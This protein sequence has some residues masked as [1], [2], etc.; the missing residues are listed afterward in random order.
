MFPNEMDCV[1]CE[2]G[3]C[4]NTVKNGICCENYQQININVLWGV[5]FIVGKVNCF[6]SG[7]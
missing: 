1:K 4:K 3:T 7:I 5:H 2:D 6:I